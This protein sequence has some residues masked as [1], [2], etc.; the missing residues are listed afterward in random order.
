MIIRGG[1]CQ[2]TI[3]P[4]ALTEASVLW[5]SVFARERG[6]TFVPSSE[7]LGKRRIELETP[8]TKCTLREESTQ[9]FVL[10][11]MQMVG[12]PTTR[13]AVLTFTRGAT[14]LKTSSKYQHGMKEVNKGKGESGGVVLELDVCHPRRAPECEQIHSHKYFLRN[15]HNKHEKWLSTHHADFPTF[16]VSEK[17][18]SWPS[19]RR[20]AIDQPILHLAFYFVRKNKEV[21]AILARGE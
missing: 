21:M 7:V 13:Q 2:Y 18:W 6:R 15:L 8:S 17:C 4:A 5:V 19:L 16:A 10:V 3:F 1:P 20:P 11:L 9:S 14:G 12:R